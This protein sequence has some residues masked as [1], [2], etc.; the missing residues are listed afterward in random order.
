MNDYYRFIEGFP[1]YRIS[2]RGNVESCWVRRGRYR[3][4]TETWLPLSPIIRDGYATVNLPRE[5]G[6]AIRRIHR[7]VL[8]VFEG[9]GPAGSIAC[10]RDGDRLNNDISNLYWG[11]QQTNSDDAVR[12]GTKARG[13]ALRSKLTE[14]AVIEI[15]RLREQ[16][17]SMRG[18][19]D[20]F[21]VSE[22]NVRSIVRGRT[23][24]HLL[25]DGEHQRLDAKAIEDRGNAA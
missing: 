19:G 3:L 9:P 17:L 22:S 7:L 1:G 18:L 24:R 25:P 12:H 16:G 15:R 11:T 20:R 10:H 4:P 23:W 6:K 2:R 5:G 21:D 14:T 8:E 13:E